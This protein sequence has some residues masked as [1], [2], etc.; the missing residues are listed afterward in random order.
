MIV[1]VQIFLSNFPIWLA[2]SPLTPVS[3]SSSNNVCCSCCCR[4]NNRATRVSSPPDKAYFNGQAGNSGF[5]LAKKIHE[6]YSKNPNINCL[7]LMNHGIFTFANNAKEAYN[8]MIKY[9]SLAEREVKKCAWVCR[10]YAEKSADYLSI[11]AIESDAS[12]SF[13]R[14]DPLGLV[15]SIMPWNFPFWQ[16]FRFAAPTLMAGNGTLLKHAPNVPQCAE[17]IESL[18]VE[19]GFPSCLL[20]NLVIDTDPVADLP[21]LRFEEFAT[22]R[23]F[24]PKK[25]VISA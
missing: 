9:V 21:P 15:L 25:Y 13:I 17:A 16:V 7:I 6:I 24:L 1:L 12:R 19:S 14:Y 10:H 18:F 5:M 4:F 22:K 20:T 2:T 8:L 11:Q 23:S 3:T